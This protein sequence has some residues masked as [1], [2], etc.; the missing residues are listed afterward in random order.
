MDL[1]MDIA[2]AETAAGST[3]AMVVCGNQNYDSQL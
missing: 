2:N 1:P 3:A